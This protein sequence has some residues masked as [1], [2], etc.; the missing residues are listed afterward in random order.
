M[1]RSS[2]LRGVGIGAGY[3]APFHYE[4]WTRIPK[5][6][7]GAICDRSE[8]KA[9]AIMAQYDVP[10]FYGDWKQMI[11]VEKPDFVD[12]ITPP[13]SHEEIC[14]Y[15]AARN[16]DI[17]CQKPL[18]PTMQAARRIVENAKAADVRLMVHENWRWQPWYRKIK[19]ISNT[20]IIGSFTQHPRYDASGRW[21]GR[22]S[23]QSPA[24]L[25]PRLPLN[26]FSTK[27][28]CI[29]SILSGS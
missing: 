5:V 2:R 26:C 21:L 11:D 23:L 27:P 14:A 25:L 1:T 12:I 10:R 28:E 4:A 20:G 29:S 8:S 19:E 3:F 18:A 15:A 16:I 24:A 6:E 13:D 7:V 17:V 9:R 22:Y